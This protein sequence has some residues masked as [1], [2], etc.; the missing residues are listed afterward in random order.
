MPHISA[1]IREMLGFFVARI[2]QIFKTTCYA[3]KR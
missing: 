1:G 2:L 3:K